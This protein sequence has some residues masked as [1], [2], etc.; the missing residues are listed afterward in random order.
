[1]ILNLLSLFK[2]VQN[3]RKGTFKRCLEEL[4]DE[5]S[6]IAYVQRA[7]DN[8]DEIFIVDLRN[9]DI[10]YVWERI[11]ELKENQEHWDESV[12]TILPILDYAFFERKRKGENFATTDE[13]MQYIPSNVELSIEELSLFLNILQKS[14]S[15]LH[16]VD[17]NVIII[18]PAWIIESFGKIF[19]PDDNRLIKTRRLFKRTGKIHADE[20]KNTM[21]RI[22]SNKRSEAKK[23]T[24]SKDGKVLTD[25]FKFLG[26]I[27]ESDNEVIIPS[28]LQEKVDTS[29]TEGLNLSNTL[30]IFYEM[31]GKSLDSIHCNKIVAVILQTFFK[32]KTGK[33][34]AEQENCRRTSIGQTCGIIDNECDV[35]VIY[36]VIDSS[37]S[38]ILYHRKKGAKLSL[39]A[40]GMTSFLYNIARLNNV[41]HK[42]PLDFK[43]RVLDKNDE[44]SSFDP[45]GKV[46]YWTTRVRNQ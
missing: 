16:L 5:I 2:K 42:K 38:L 18:N 14:G 4:K 39:G 40:D 27:V 15:L 35:S 26:L 12:P 41:Y 31:N 44:Y 32:E 1:M 11:K 7:N 29:I 23:N 43:L 6:K 30:T 45:D 21:L 19:C 13:T 24:M 28:F 22:T 17:N 8:L 9:D 10:A 46:E 20:F 36:K 25:A 37:V 34:P 33:H 3:E